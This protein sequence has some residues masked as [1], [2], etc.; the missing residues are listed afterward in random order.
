MKLPV[1]VL[2]SAGIPALSFTSRGNGILVRLSS[3]EDLPELWSPTTTS[4]IS[5]RF[6]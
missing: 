4:Y 1:V 2:S 6:E 5:I 3:K